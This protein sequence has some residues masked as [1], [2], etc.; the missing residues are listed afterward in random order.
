MGVFGF[1]QG[2][3]GVIHKSYRTFDMRPGDLTNELLVN[4]VGA[5]DEDATKGYHG[6]GGAGNINDVK[7]NYVGAEESWRKGLEQQG[8]PN[9][10]HHHYFADS[11]K[12]IGITKPKEYKNRES[13]RWTLNKEII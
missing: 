7:N 12:D 5:V 8:E 3:K 11:R 2:I 6:G 4:A 1:F 9:F 10:G 13:S